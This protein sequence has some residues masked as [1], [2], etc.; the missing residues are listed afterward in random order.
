MVWNRL[1][2]PPYIGW[3]EFAG[4]TDVAV[5]GEVGEVDAVGVVATVGVVG[6]DGDSW[7]HEAIRRE[8][9]IMQLTRN[10]VV[11]LAIFIPLLLFLMKPGY[12]RATCAVKNRIPADLKSPLSE[13]K[14]FIRYTVW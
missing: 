7:P 9:T 6:V 13:Q 3:S 8:R 14:N 10:Q 5:E 4:A 11:F 2:V 12:V 1:C